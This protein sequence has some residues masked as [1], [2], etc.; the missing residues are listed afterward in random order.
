M[1]GSLTINTT[2]VARDI[3]TGT[4]IVSV[5]ANSI[6]PV[7]F[8]ATVI[9]IPVPN[10]IPVTTSTTSNSVTTY[11]FRYNYAQQ[12]TN[13][14]ESVSLEEAALTT[15]VSLCAAFSILP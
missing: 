14:I 2:P 12:I 11:V 3:T 10:P 4:N 8:S 9:D 1:P 6:T 7:T 15:T 5:T 13:L